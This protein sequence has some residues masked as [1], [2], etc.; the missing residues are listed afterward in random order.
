MM[1]SRVFDSLLGYKSAMAQAG[2]M[3]SRGIITADEY[4]TIDTI[5]AQK[6][7]LSS[8]SVFRENDLLYRSA[9]GNMSHN[10]VVTECQK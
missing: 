2:L 3:L 4:V 6:Y 10:Q 7:G 9:G 1:D 5:M 8:C